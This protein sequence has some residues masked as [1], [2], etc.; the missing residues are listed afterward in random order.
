M[1]GVYADLA[2]IYDLIGMADFSAAMTPQLVDFAQRHDWLGRRI[3]DLG[4][5][6]GAGVRWL[7][8]RGYIVT[9]VDVSPEM[10]AQA[11]AALNSEHLNADLLERDIRDLGPDLVATDL[12]LALDV[13]NELNSLRDLESVFRSV[14]AVLNVGKMF[15]FDLHTIQ[16]L[17]EMG[18]QGHA[19]ARDTADLTVITADQYDYER[20]VNDR[21]YLVFQRVGQAWRRTEANRALRAFPAQAVATLLQRC[22][23]QVSHVLDLNFNAFEPG[24]SRAARVVFVAE[25]R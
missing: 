18:M 14:H 11:R 9:G 12:A 17:A 10:L 21:R 3:V 6:T 13:L 2:P 15:I 16:G 19:V 22:G 7:A 1:S 23:F 5:G 4:C 8:Q 24:V 25:K 20:Q